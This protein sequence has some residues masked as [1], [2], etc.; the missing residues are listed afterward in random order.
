MELASIPA[1]SDASSLWENTGQGERA[2]E[3][4]R[5]G[6]QQGEVR[7]SASTVQLGC[8]CPP[9]YE[10]ILAP[11]L[12]FL[13]D[14]FLFLVCRVLSPN[15]SLTSPSEVSTSSTGAVTIP[16][17]LRQWTPVPRDLLNISPG[18]LPS[19]LAPPGFLTCSTLGLEMPFHIC[20][21]NGC[22]SGQASCPGG[23]IAILPDPSPY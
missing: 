14:S 12:H 2:P 9:W 4:P 16:A 11:G 10:P 13:L 17:L 1:N 23:L 7:R 20:F 21:A 3:D 22:L 19:F 15:F 5:H 18:F 6:P 8:T